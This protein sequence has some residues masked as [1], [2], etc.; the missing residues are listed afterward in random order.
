[1]GNIYVELISDFKSTNGVLL[2]LDKE[3]LRIFRSAMAIVTKLPGAGESS[4]IYNKCAHRFI[5]GGDRTVILV[6]PDSVTW[7]LPK[8]KADEILAALDALEEA[9][10]PCHDY[11]DID[12]PPDTLLISKDEYVGH[13]A[14]SL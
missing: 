10:H 13:V 4:V 12:S 8:L 2:A 14:D 11:I 9:S 1:M 3:G 6:E 5:V 7:Y